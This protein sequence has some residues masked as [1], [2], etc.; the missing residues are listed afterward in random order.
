MTST[1]SPPPRWLDLGA[2]II[3]IDA[4]LNRPAQVAFYLLIEGDQA[5]FIDTGTY[6]SL[7]NALATLQANGLTPD[8]VAYVIP[9]HVHLDHAGGAGI[10]MREFPRAK[11]V[12]HPRGARHMIDPTQLFD[13]V[14]QIY[15]TE[16][17]EHQYGKPI[18]VAADRMIEA[19]DN[20]TLALNGRP[21]LFLDTPGHARHHFCVFDERT[22]TIFSGDTFGVS[23]R[24]LDT[25]RG[26]FIFPTTSPVQFE[27]DALHRSVDRLQALNP[28]Q[29]VLTHFGRVAE[30]ARLA[31]DM[32][33]VI[34]AFVRLGH[35]V[36]D[37]GADRQRLLMDGQHDI[38]MPRLRAHGCTMDNARVLSLLRHDYDLN[39]QGIGIWLDRQAA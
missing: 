28:Q 32:H 6:G 26:A 7:P 34:D 8:Q 18:P 20:F 1:G 25:P 30:T 27:P 35:R 10:M 11:L 38:L 19:P 2:G 36:R 4:E 22:G 3:C 39:A 37:T 15:G 21:L 13:G 16:R 12:V 24:E 33:T 31:A 9:T 23:Y 29:I 14:A 17:A 5:A